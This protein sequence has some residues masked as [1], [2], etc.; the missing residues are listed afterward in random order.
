MEDLK[1]CRGQ[2]QLAADSYVFGYEQILAAVSKYII[3]RLTDAEQTAAIDCRTPGKVTGMARS[4]P[5][6]PSS[7]ASAIA[8]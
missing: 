5:P 7:S 8:D 4:V 3:L 6:P 1:L 2:Q